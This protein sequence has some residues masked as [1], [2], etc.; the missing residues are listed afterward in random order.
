MSRQGRGL[1]VLTA[2]GIILIP[3]RTFFSLELTT[4][5]LSLHAKDLLPW[6]CL[7]ATAKLNS[8]ISGIKTNCE[9][10]RLIQIYV[11]LQ[12]GNYAALE[13]GLRPMSS[14]YKNQSLQDEVCMTANDCMWV[15]C[16]NLTPPRNDSILVHRGKQFSLLL[17]SEV[18]GFQA[19]EQ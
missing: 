16:A 6:M 12:W 14:S 11:T 10:F 9:C 18:L 7:A 1:Q 4:Y 3:S 2:S 19:E 13:T 17:P 8:V 5:Q 15:S